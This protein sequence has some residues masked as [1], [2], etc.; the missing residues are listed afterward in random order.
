[1]FWMHTNSQR[2]PQSDFSDFY[3]LSMVT[4]VFELWC[5]TDQQKNTVAGNF[6]TN[7]FFLWRIFFLNEYLFEMNQKS[8]CNQPTNRTPLKVAPSCVQNR[9]PL[10]GL[11]FNW[12]KF[13][14]PERKRPSKETPAEKSGSK[15]I[16]L[17]VNTFQDHQLYMNVY[18]FPVC[19]T[20][21]LHT[22]YY[23]RFFKF[24]YNASSS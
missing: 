23:E 12:P 20:V 18:N 17:C 9:R 6:E 2:N 7:F 3:F 21:H 4:W 5:V 8:I 24:W 1:M 14:G 13:N 19:C 22:E 10:V 16:F 15:W 11:L